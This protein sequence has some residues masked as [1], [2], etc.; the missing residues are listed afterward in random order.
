MEN[1]ETR[2]LNLVTKGE[3]NKCKIEITD[4]CVGIDEES[5]PRLF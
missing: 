4:T 5:L 3:N 1:T 2:V